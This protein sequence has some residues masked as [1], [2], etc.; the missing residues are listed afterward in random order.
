MKLIPSL[1]LNVV[2][3]AVGLLVY[4]QLRDEPQPPP[5]GPAFVPPALVTADSEEEALLPSEP[6]FTEE[7]VRRFA[8]LLERAEAVRRAEREHERMRR[9]FERLELDVSADEVKAV[10]AV[11][12][13]YRTQTRA[14]LVERA[15]ARDGDARAAIRER[16]RALRV[17]F[18]AKVQEVLP[19]VDAEKAALALGRASGFGGRE[20]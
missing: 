17:E 2:V 9:N 5:A 11:V 15:G 10:L 4:D 12:A 7:E 14:V 18:T 3:V 1:L 19:N 8:R 13:E 16:L 6:E 20:R